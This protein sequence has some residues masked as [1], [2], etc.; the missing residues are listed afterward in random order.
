MQILKRQVVDEDGGA[1]VPQARWI[2]YGS[3]VLLTLI[4]QSDADRGAILEAIFSRSRVELVTAVAGA[5]AGAARERAERAL[6]A[7]DY[8]YDVFESAQG[9]AA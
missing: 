2:K 5:G 6:R 3:R 8:V 1:L 7:H 4:E 9:A